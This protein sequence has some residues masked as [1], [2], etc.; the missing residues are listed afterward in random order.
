MLSSPATETA[1][2]DVPVEAAAAEPVLPVATE[3]LS[4][5]EKPPGETAPPVAAEDAA[6]DD[7]VPVAAAVPVPV[8]PEESAVPATVLVP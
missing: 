8:D 7:A 3:L 1:E 4:M 6:A 5:E 2:V